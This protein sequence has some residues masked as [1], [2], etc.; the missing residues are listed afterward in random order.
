[1]DTHTNHTAKSSL[2]LDEDYISCIVGKVSKRKKL[3]ETKTEEKSQRNK[4]NNLI[5]KAQASRIRN[6][7]KP[8]SPTPTRMKG[9]ER[10]TYIIHSTIEGDVVLETVDGTY[11]SHQ[12]LWDI[13]TRKQQH[14]QR[15]QA[16]GESMKV[17]RKGADISGKSCRREMLL[18]G[19]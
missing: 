17:E 14:T 11:S 1:M 18:K 3:W 12:E 8:Q 4:D 15:L 7:G 13:Q 6:R 2:D 16:S 10:V 19:D 9:K 5:T